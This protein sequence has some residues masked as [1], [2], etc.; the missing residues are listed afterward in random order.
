MGNSVFNHSANGL[1]ESV[2]DAIEILAT[3]K[4]DEANFDKTIQATILECTSNT[5]GE[6]KCRYQDSKFLA[7]TPNP[8]ITYKE[9]T[10]VYILVPGN[11]WDATK[12]I[13][14][15]VD[16][17]GVD[18]LATISNKDYF[19]PIGDS[20]IESSD[21]TFDLN[22]WDGSNFIT[23]YSKD[24]D[25]NLIGLNTEK[26]ADYFKDGLATY[27]YIQADFQSKIENPMLGH[28]GIKITT[29]RES[30]EGTKEYF[31][32]SEDMEGEPR[33]F[34]EYSTQGNSKKPFLIETAVN[35][36]TTVNDFG[37][38]IKIE[39]FVD[40]FQAEEGHEA[41]IHVKNFR[42]GALYR[43]SEMEMTNGYLSIL[44]PLGSIFYATAG[45]GY[46]P[47]NLRMTA[48][49]RLNGI[50]S[51]DPDIKYYWFRRD[52]RV[53]GGA[54]DDF[55][56]Y[57]CPISGVNTNGW[58]CLNSSTTD[59][60]NNR[61]WNPAG[62]EYTLSIGDIP[63]QEMYYM[64]VAIYDDMVMSREITMRNKVAD[65][66]ITIESTGGYHFYQDQGET[67][68][69]CTAIWSSGA[70]P[71]DLHYYWAKVTSEGIF[72]SIWTDTPTPTDKVEA[73]NIIGFEKYFCTVYSQ[74]RYIG[75]GYCILTNSDIST[76]DSFYLN[77]TNGSQSF[78]YDEDG[79]SPVEKGQNIAPL[80]VE[81]YNNLGEQLTPEEVLHSTNIKWYVPKE[82]TMIVQP[83]IPQEPYE[84][85]DP[86][87]GLVYWVY[88]NIV[89]L[90]FRIA[91]YYNFSYQN[92][93][94]KL[95]VEY[96]GNTYL[97]KTTFIFLQEGDLGT[98]GTKY[99]C[100][101]VP[102]SNSDFTQSRVWINEKS[103]GS[104][105]FNFNYPSNEFPFRALIYR[106][107]ELIY[108]GYTS[109]S[110]Q[111]INFGITW[112]ISDGDSNS[113][114][115]LSGTTFTYKGF[116]STIYADPYNNI[117]KVTITVSTVEGKTLYSFLPIGVTK[118]KSASL[119]NYK[120]GL[121]KEGDFYSGFTQ[122]IYNTDGEN[123][124]FNELSPFRPVVY[125]ADDEDVT[126]NFNIVQSFLGSNLIYEN[127][128]S[129]PPNLH[130]IPSDYYEGIDVSNAVLYA[131][132]YFTIYAP[133]VF[134]I[135]RYGLASL[136]AWD[137]THIEIN[138]EEG[139]IYA[140]QIGAGKKENDNSFTGVLLGKVDIPNSNEKVGLM[141]YGHGKR[142]VWVDANTGKAEF[143][144]G[145][146]KIVIDPDHDNATVYG[147]GYDLDP[148]TGMCINLSAPSIKWG[149]GNFEVN[150]EGKIIAMNM[151]LNRSGVHAQSLYYSIDENGLLIDIGHSGNYPTNYEPSAEHK[152]FVL[153]SSDINPSTSLIPAYHTNS[154]AEFGDDGVLLQ[155]LDTK[156]FLMMKTGN[157]ETDR[158]SNV[159][160][161][162][163]NA[164][165]LSSGIGD[166]VP[167][168]DDDASDTEKAEDESNRSNASVVVKSAYNADI[169]AGHGLSLRVTGL[170]EKDGGAHSNYPDP[171]QN[172]TYGYMKLETQYG[173][174]YL[175][176]KAGGKKNTPGIG[177]NAYT[178][179]YR[180]ENRGESEGDPLTPYPGQD[181]KVY[182]NGNEIL[183]SE[184]ASE[185]TGGDLGGAVYVSEFGN[186][187]PYLD[188]LVS[189]GSYYEEGDGIAAWK[190]VVT[191][192]TIT[193]SDA[194]EK[195]DFGI[196]DRRYRDFVMRLKPHKYRYK[197]D[198]KTS[199]L[200]TG[201]MA[202]EVENALENSGIALWEFGGLKKQPIKM[203]GQTV[204]YGYGLNYDDFVAALVVTVQDLQKQIND[205]K[206]ELKYGT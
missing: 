113:F 137:G 34:V 164:L 49:I 142:T 201:F 139:Y 106:N 64:C 188:N 12:T 18:Y 99:I 102:N 148:T 110:A 81:F 112:S 26:V 123:P 173:W 127:P 143:G 36:N 167:G 144:A 21:A 71:A 98:N 149:N 20:V 179:K 9:D 183:T 89:N 29:S 66:E 158:G 58:A 194:R 52:A 151:Q 197:K 126:D 79:V 8:D 169:W 16:K 56:D 38:V 125:N 24:D 166:I 4:I 35:E 186:L 130:I 31:Y 168:P 104:W 90:P 30:K 73:I 134:A 10:L 198:E 114:Y 154:V 177:I 133:V 57:Y 180:E 72:S 108:S 39:L 185:A 7:Y 153:F 192:D 120:I 3:R 45:G 162:S 156:S 93:Q 111:D 51:D 47:A 107:S 115:E 55:Q 68:L 17:L 190:H 32:M 178:W 181:Y 77:I 205:L 157:D 84:Y 80:E 60:Q 50:I 6:Y 53:Y 105:S 28:Y 61:T 141:A 199:P 41:D 121:F 70:T 163:N 85:T 101:I 145:T 96:K 136:N 152:K 42:M 22:S 86:I 33:N 195:D 174:I 59:S 109:G 182:I 14:G 54:Q 175:S 176:S 131:N 129:D 69:S 202:Q 46:T 206:G 27:F 161:M 118:I 62:N 67:N 196:L 138:E 184:N 189:L 13:I 122:A 160:L 165:Y 25:I 147:G 76:T 187:R 132:T 117:L 204:D 172:G 78:K 170:H 65:C 95:T 75:T 94:I 43:L 116:P 15:T 11:D 2:L 146:G 83:D 103:D 135:N 23:V 203:Y 87:S 155:C 91:N 140:P 193:V 5:K 171:I 1:A 159:A 97:D 92:N 88:E 19:D 40:N 48:R 191:Y 63:T 200:R 100:K 82:R 150:S 44:T 74:N 124:Q 128:D 37:E 119:D